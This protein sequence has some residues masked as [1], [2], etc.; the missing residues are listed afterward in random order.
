M[1]KTEEQLRLQENDV[2][3]TECYIVIAGDYIVAVVYADIA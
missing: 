2:M 1:E 3:D